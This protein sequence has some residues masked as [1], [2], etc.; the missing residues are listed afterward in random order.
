MV[1]VLTLSTVYHR[2]EPRMDPTKDYKTGICCFSAKHAALRS[3]KK[4]GLARNQMNNFTKKRMW[5]TP[6]VHLLLCRGE[7]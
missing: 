1:I 2:F 4:D 5:G 3:K 7:L 6:I